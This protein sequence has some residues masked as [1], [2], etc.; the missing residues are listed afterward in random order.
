MTGTNAT[1]AWVDSMAARRKANGHEDV[2]QYRSELLA[3]HGLVPRTCRSPLGNVRNV[4]A[5]GTTKFLLVYVAVSRE[6][7]DRE[8]MAVCEA[9]FAK[10]FGK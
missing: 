7:N 9:E 1:V 3:K 5:M 10:R 4:K 6:A 8:A 2:E